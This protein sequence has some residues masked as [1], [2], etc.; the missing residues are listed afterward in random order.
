ML[1]TTRSRRRTPEEPVSQDFSATKQSGVGTEWKSHD[2]QRRADLNRHAR[3]EQVLGRKRT[4]DR[5]GRKLG[6]LDF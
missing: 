5:P 6:A 3:S 4:V 2:E 1:S